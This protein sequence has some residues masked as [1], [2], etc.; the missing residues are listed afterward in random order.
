[1]SELTREEVLGFMERRLDAIR[2]EAESTASYVNAGS[3]PD[4]L[5]STANTLLRLRGA[6]LELAIHLRVAH[7]M[8]PNGRWPHPEGTCTQCG[9]PVTE[10]ETVCVLCKRKVDT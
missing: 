6:E 8:N 3:S 10:G 5:Q 7:G 2:R 4:H 1:M 9:R